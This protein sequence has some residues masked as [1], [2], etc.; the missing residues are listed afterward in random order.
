[1]I[2]AFA[3]LTLDFVASEANGFGLQLPPAQPG[4]LPNAGLDGVNARPRD[5]YVPA[6]R[7]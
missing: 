5:Q 1:M 7:M 2:L 6:E 4:E 3:G